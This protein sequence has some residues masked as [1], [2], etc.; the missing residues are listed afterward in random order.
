M[1]RFLSFFILILV[2]G[3]VYSQENNFSVGLDKT[4]IT[5]YK[6]GGGMLG[7]SMAFNVSERVETK[8]YARTFVLKDKLDKKAA[9]VEC[10]LCFIPSELKSAVIDILQLSDETQEFNEENVLIMAQHTH[11]GPAGYCHYASYNMSVP[12]FIPEIFEWLSWQIA[13]SIIKANQKI[14]SCSISLSKGYFPE[15]WGVA[16]NRSLPAYNRN[17]DVVPLS[18]SQ[19]NLAVNREMTLLQFKGENSLPLG[20]LNWFGVHATSISNDI[21]A[22]NADNKGYAATYLENHFLKLN[23]DFVGAFAQGTAGDVTPKF[24]FNPKRHWQR[25]YWEGKFPDDVES[26]K[27]NGLLQYKKAV[28]LIESKDQH[29]VAESKIHCALRYFDFSSILID[30]LYTH[31]A[32]VKKTSPSCI[33]MDMLGGALMDGPAAPKMVVKLSKVWI[34]IFKAYELTKARIIRSEDSQKIFEKYEAQGPKAIALETGSKR[35]L[36][37]KNVKKIPIPNFVDP[38]IATF[39]LYA[40]RDALKEQAWSPQV[41]PVQFVEIGDLVLVSIP[42]EITTTAGR[43]LKKGIEELYAQEGKREVILCPYA[44]SYSGYITT[45]EEYQEQMYEGGHT[46]FGQYGLAALQTTFKRLYEVKDV[47]FCTT[48]DELCPPVFSE[49]ELGK[50]LFYERKNV[51]EK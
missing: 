2:S 42:F 48:P 18:H 47:P 14:V 29:F 23:P 44:N 22:I 10:E 38:T 43:R 25:G 32:D 5:I 37:A 13:Q 31:T 36:G 19:R 46:V 11:C 8:L 16:F 49:T 28:E 41:L 40:N 45:F 17:E 24:V 1:L 15:D 34:R 39:K 4:D 3:S 26:A 35:L 30:T 50:R 20:S 12:G 21:T 7:Y 33:G 6:K 27:Y 51:K 9:I